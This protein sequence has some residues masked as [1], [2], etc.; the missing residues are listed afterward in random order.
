MHDEHGT[1]TKGAHDPA[2]ALRPTHAVGRAAL[3]ILP[4]GLRAAK[5]TASPCDRAEKFGTPSF[6]DETV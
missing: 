6:R 4:N 1:A 3:H 2:N 5:P